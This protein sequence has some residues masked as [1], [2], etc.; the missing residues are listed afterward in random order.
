M[1]KLRKRAIAKSVGMTYFKEGNRYF[2]KVGR[3]L[4]EHADP[5][6]ADAYMYFVNEW[7]ERRKSPQ[8]LRSRTMV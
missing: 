1:R 4:V 7:K 8:P 6:D 5:T 3:E 2:V